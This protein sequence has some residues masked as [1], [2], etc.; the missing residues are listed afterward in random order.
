M[1]KRIVLPVLAV[2]GL[3][4]ALAGC[5]GMV[6]SGG[7]GNS[8]NAPGRGYKWGQGGQPRLV[9]IEGTGIQYVA[10][11]D[12]DIYFLDGVWYRYSWGNWY[13]CRS[14]GGTWVTIGAP[15][16][17]FG[18]IPPGHAKFH[19]VEMKDPG[20]PDKGPSPGHGGNPGKGPK[21]K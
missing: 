6:S 5:T 7:P 20:P 4:L 19:K 18:R 21:W 13:T 12:D 17:A 9:V 3:M 14:M 8:G 2:A 1:S 16:Q 10:D 15:P 11:C